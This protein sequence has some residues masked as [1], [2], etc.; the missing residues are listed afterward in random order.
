MSK[1]LPPET[2]VEVVLYK[3]MTFKEYKK[4][5]EKPKKGWTVKAYQQGFIK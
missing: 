5:L 4:L 1:E 2:I 3:E